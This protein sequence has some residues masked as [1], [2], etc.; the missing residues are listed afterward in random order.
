MDLDRAHAFAETWVA[1]WNAHDLD[2]MAALGSARDVAYGI[3]AVALVLGPRR[4][5]T[6]AG[7]ASTSRMPRSR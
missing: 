5:E 6:R 4:P 7:D 3:A 1:E 2:R